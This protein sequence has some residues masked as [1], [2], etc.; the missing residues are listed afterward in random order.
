MALG[1][2]VTFQA[3][4]VSFT[5]MSV[6]FKWMQKLSQRCSPSLTDVHFHRMTMPGYRASPEGSTWWTMGKATASLASRDTLPRNGPIA[7]SHKVEADQFCSSDGPLPSQGPEKMT[8]PAPDP[9]AFTRLPRPIPGFHFPELSTQGTPDYPCLSL[10]TQPLCLTP[11]CHLCWCHCSPRP[12]PTVTLPS[13][14]SVPLLHP[15]PCPKL[16]HTDSGSSCWLV[17]CL[18][19]VPTLQSI[20]PGSQKDLKC[21]CDQAA[22]KLER[23]HGCLVACEECRSPLSP[24]PNVP[25]PC[26]SIL[27]LCPSA[28]LG[29]LF[30]FWRKI[31]PE[32]ASTANPPLFF[33]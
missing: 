10:S 33:R 12:C 3:V 13:P 17:L 24:S 16:S 1:V 5:L 9:E 22:P 7:A 25:Q 14:E 32:L 8:V 11:L 30:F 31:S 29:L 26:L 6:P 15:R 27:A 23:R 18:R 21:K 20:F 4:L 28:C 2:I 19:P